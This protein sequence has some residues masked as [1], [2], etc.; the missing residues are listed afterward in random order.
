MRSPHT[1]YALS[2][3]ADDKLRRLTDAEQA[4][5]QAMKEAFDCGFDVEVRVPAITAALIGRGSIPSVI[6][7]VRLLLS[8]GDRFTLS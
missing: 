8:P 2:D 6:T 3:E 7:V 4:Y 1:M 5:N